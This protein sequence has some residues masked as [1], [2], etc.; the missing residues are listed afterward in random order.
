MASIDPTAVIILS[1]I[2]LIETLIIL[3]V[4]AYLIFHKKKTSHKLKALLDDRNNDEADRKSS[5][6]KTF[7]KFPHLEAN[8]IDTI[9]ENIVNNEKQF[10]QYSINAFSQNSLSRLDDLYAEICTLV[11]P[12][13]EF[14][15]K[16]TSQS[17]T[18]EKPI[19]TDADTII[20]ELLEDTD[21]NEEGDPALDLS[22]SAEEMAE[23]PDELLSVD[24]TSEKE[25]TE[26]S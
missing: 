9:V 13:A 14:T 6:K 1:E 22:N 16:A 3:G 25:F 11:A 21:D 19:I 8:D 23:I 7:Y 10:F 17:R 24:S 4:A 20:D 5:L 12:Y 18:E 26:N 2:I 15:Q